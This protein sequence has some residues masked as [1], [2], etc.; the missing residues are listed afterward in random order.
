MKS[1][2]KDGND[3]MHYEDEGAEHN[4]K[5]WHARLEK[6]LFS[7]SAINSTSTIAGRIAAARNI[8]QGRLP[9]RVPAPDNR[10][11]LSIHYL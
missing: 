11:R 5:A 3:L 9:W 1:G 4:E 6:P 10:R 8:P 7:S 2:Y